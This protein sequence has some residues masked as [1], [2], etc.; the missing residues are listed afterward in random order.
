MK[1]NNMKALEKTDDYKNWDKLI[2][3]CEVLEGLTDFEREKAKHAFHFLREELGEEFL[4]EAFDKRHPICQ[5]IIN[6]APWTRKWLTW[7]AEALKELR[8][9]ENYSSLLNRIKDE[10]KFNEGLS[11][12][13]FAYKFSKAGFE[14]SI[15]PVIKIS[16]REKI[17]DLMLIDKDTRE[18]L[19]VEVSEVGKSRLVWNAF[20]TMQRIID[21][22]WSSVPFIHYCG[23]IHKIL[24][25][26]H[27]EFIVKKI[28]EI[29]EKVKEENSFQEL[30]IED[31]IEIGIAPEK[32][33]QLLEKWAAE[34]GL[35]V[36]EFSG[37][38]FNVD[39][40]LRTKRAIEKEQRQLPREYPNVLIIRNNNLFFYIRDIRK[41][42]SELEEEVY[43]Y[44]HL[45]I[46]I[47][48]G[49]Y[50]GKREDIISMKDQHVFIKKTTIDS[51]VEQYII[52]LNKF[53]EHKIYPGTITKIY[54]AF[55]N[56]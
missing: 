23:Q 56:Y 35:K 48:A 32:D 20:Q 12:L 13:E 5:Y 34:R 47:I 17:P 19:F 1:T 36:G 3:H 15:D 21:P 49:K 42:I 39:E 37:P 30:V 55:K 6:L 29:T 44:Q 22:L 4:N 26:P 18:K 11:V 7:F 33:I 50:L 46:S 40:I 2:Q 31:V 24:S 38:P 16:N 54:N 27:L 43:E 45:L 28:K 9:Q 14:V 10:S 8:R 53:C 52:L 41:L 51:L 25:Q